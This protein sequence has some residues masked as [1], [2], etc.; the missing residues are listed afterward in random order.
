MA[1]LFPIVRLQISASLFLL[2]RS[3]ALF[4]I[5][6]DKSPGPDGFNSCFYKAPWDTIGSDVNK[7]VL[8]F[9]QSGK[10]LKE[11]N[12]TSLNMIPK[13]KHPVFVA[14]FRPIACCSIL[15]KVISK[16]LCSRLKLVLP[17]LISL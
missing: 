6:N 16:L 12:N 1:R 2:L 9:F 14:D 7:D 15:Y 10:L 5:L 11:I 8:N 3:K 13:V 4:S 17:S